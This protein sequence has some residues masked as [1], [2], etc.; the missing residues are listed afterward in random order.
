MDFRKKNGRLD[1]SMDYRP[2]DDDPSILP[3]S[4]CKRHGSFPFLFTGDIK[5]VSRSTAK[6]DAAHPFF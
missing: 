3:K 1:V 4:K 5:Q 2:S 6:A